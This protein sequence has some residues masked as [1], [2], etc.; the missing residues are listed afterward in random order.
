MGEVGSQAEPSAELAARGW[1]EAEQESEKAEQ[2]SEEADSR[3][4]QDAEEGEVEQ[5]GEERTW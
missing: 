4:E 1:G 5:D 2:E 3:A